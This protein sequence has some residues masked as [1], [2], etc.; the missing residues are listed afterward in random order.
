[1]SEKQWDKLFISLILV[2]FILIS[3]AI[4]LTIVNNEPIKNVIYLVEVK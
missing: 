3:L 4:T 2:I 1:M